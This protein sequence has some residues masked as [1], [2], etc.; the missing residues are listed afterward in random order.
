MDNFTPLRNGILEHLRDG[1]MC[2]F[3]LGVYVLLHLRADWETGI[4]HGCAL[5]LAYQ[6]GDSTLRKHITNSLARLRSRG[7]INYRKG[8]MDAGKLSHPD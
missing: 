1:K 2:P 3:D 7:Y 6:F 5:A 8:V 4:Y